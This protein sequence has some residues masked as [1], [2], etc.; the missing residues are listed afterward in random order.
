MSHEAAAACIQRMKSDP[1]FSARV[2]AIADPEARLALIASEGYPCTQEDL[3]TVSSM[4]GDKEL[5]SVSGGIC[6]FHCY[7]CG[8]SAA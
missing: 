6:T 8:R 3:A 2:L 4:I 1:D 5:D 7:R